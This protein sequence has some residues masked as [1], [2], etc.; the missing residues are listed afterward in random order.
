MVQNKLCWD[1]NDTVGL[2]KQRKVEL[3]QYELLCFGI[4]TALFASQWNLFRT[5]WLDPAKGLLRHCHGLLTQN[6]LAVIQN[7]TENSFSFKH[8]CFHST[9][10]IYQLHVPKIKTNVYICRL[11]KINRVPVSEMKRNK[12]V[13]LFYLFSML[14]ASLQNDFLG[15]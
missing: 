4:P 2:W 14:C 3:G 10:T 9:G 1:V 7:L 11:C 5:T 8:R 12:I 6:W 13:F 15:G